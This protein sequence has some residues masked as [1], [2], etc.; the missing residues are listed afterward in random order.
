MSPVARYPRRDR[1]SERVSHGS[2][3]S[4]VGKSCWA[5][6]ALGIGMELDQLLQP[7]P[8]DG[9]RVPCSLLRVLGQ[10]PSGDRTSG[11]IRHKAQHDVP[12]ITRKSEQLPN[13]M[14]SG[15]DTVGGGYG[16]NS[17]P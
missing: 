10:A 11:G 4:W 6:V 2:L 15:I 1:K 13:Y 17:R 7:T 12:R 14:E 8:G 16:T 5:M 3:G 9:T